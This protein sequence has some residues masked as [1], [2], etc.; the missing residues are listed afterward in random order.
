MV[1]REFLRPND[2]L[3]NI[4]SQN[5]VGKIAY[6]ITSPNGTKRKFLNPNTFQ[7]LTANLVN[8]LNH[9]NQ[10]TVRKGN[11][12][13]Q[14]VIDPYFGGT[15]HRSRTKLVMLTGGYHTARRVLN[16]ENAAEKRR[17]NSVL[18]RG[19]N[20]GAKLLVEKRRRNRRIPN[21]PLSPQANAS[22]RV[23]AAMRRGL[24]PRSLYGA[25]EG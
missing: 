24:R 10:F 20:I 2:N 12:G 22:R 7:H 11:Y 25:F 17:M 9:P 23:R 15:L 1:N 6:M 4:I 18:K 19:K 16:R 14:P 8:N 3:R 5:V 13:R 21:T